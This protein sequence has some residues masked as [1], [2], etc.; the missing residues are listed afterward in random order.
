MTSDY[1][2]KVYILP[3]LRGGNYNTLM[4]L[5]SNSLRFDLSDPA[6]FR[7]HVLDHY[8]KYGWRSTVD[9]FGVKKSTLYDWRRLFIISKKQINSLVPK[10]TRPNNLR[11]MTVDPKFVEFIKL[12]RESYGNVS[13]YK[14]KIFVD[15]YAKEI[16]VKTVSVSLIGKVIKRKHFFYETRTKAKRKKFRLLSPRIKRSPKE[17]LPGYIEMDSIIIYF[18]GRRYCFSTIIDI[19]TKFAWCKLIPTLS[20]SHSKQ[21]LIEFRDLYNHPVR[22]VQTDNG[23]EFLGEFNFYVEQQNIKHEFIYPRSP[24]INGVVERFNRTIQEEFLTRQGEI[25]YNKN[26]FN[27]K[28]TNYLIWYN[29]KRPHQALNYMTPKFY[30]DSFPK[31]M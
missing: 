26:L 7:L 22:I 15:E 4:K 29:T 23:S 16:G 31:C 2:K 8:Y 12:F 19:V 21:A 30:T 1:N 9:A 14:L 27:Q 25:V 17:I 13:K 24:K 28:L 5:I 18:F 3:K 10:S 11:V 6:K 20:S